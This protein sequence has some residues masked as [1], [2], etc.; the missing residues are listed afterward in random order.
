M[1]EVSNMPGHL[2]RRLHQ[3]STKVFLQRMQ[4]AGVDLT[5]VQF[6]T[7]DGLNQQPGI[8]QA[9]LAQLIDK[10]RANTG[11][12]LDRLEQKGLVKRIV[13]EKD[14]RAR[15]LSLTKDG[16]AMLKAVAP[17]VEQVQHEILP[18]LSDAEVQR[19]VSL[20]KKAVVNAS[21]G[22]TK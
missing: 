19:F 20:A 12:V 10:D 16:L 22:K 17:L 21:A 4:Q 3:V 6:A 11:S 14:K 5:P 8:D 1:T 15:T 9:G 7:L 18:G 2:I 13:S